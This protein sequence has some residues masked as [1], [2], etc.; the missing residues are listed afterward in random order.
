MKAA[1]FEKPNVF[2]VVQ[3]SLRPLRDGDLLLKVEACG[4]CGTDVHIVEGT[5]RSS[6]PVVLGHEFAGTIQD[7][8]TTHFVPGQRVA[9]DPN[10][11]CRRCFYCR[12]GLVHLCEN[13]RAL[14]VDIDG[15]I[16][17]YCVVPESQAYTLP[18]DFPVHAGAFVEPVSCAIHGIDRANI[19]AGDK[20]LI[21]GG[22]TIGLIM[23]QLAKNAGAARVFLVEPLGHKR[24][25][26]LRLGADEAIDPKV[27]DV[28][29]LIF[30]ATGVGAD[31]VIE[32]AGRMQTAQQSLELA[33]R[34]GTV[35][36]FG[37]CSLGET[38]P[39]EPNKVYFKEL[40]IVG[41]YVN[42][43]TFSRS[44]AVLAS[45]TVHVDKFQLDRFPL[46][47]VHEALTMQREGKTIKSIIEPQR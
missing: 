36:F 21:L 11:A 47:G 15:G 27:T 28:H 8:G 43:H 35:E 44:I 16:A 23:L 22:G 4:V 42:P 30:D 24:E 1:L 46:D 31:V 10:V 26:A 19:R 7:A 39:I 9:V 20:V 32:C 14:G 2:N 33:R 13:L 41:S 3:R 5:S 38:F 34:G 29:A 25:L 18:K 45:G 40:T 6:P 12:R 17:E 37:V